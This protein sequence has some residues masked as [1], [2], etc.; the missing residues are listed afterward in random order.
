MY[1]IRF[2]LY[3]SKILCLLIIRETVFIDQKQR[4]IIFGDYGT[5]ILQIGC[6]LY[7]KMKFIDISN[8]IKINCILIKN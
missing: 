8:E 1:Q 3:I 5:K 4:M 2:P 6:Q 7:W